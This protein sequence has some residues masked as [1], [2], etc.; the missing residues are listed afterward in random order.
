MTHDEDQDALDGIDLQMWRVPPPAPVDR[1]SLLVRALSPAAAP[2]RPRL[3]WIL[4]TIVLLNAALVTLVVI[5]LARSPE[6][7]TVAIV[8]PAGGG[9]VDEEVRVLLQRLEREQRELERKLAEIQ[10]LRA[11]VLELSE[12]VRQY[13]QQDG[14]RDRTVPK[15]PTRPAP[16]RIERQA[17]DPADSRCDEVYCVL[18]NYQGACCTKFRPAGMPVPTEPAPPSTLPETL[19]RAAISK[20]IAAVKARVANCGRRTEVS[21]VVKVRVRVG[22]D[23]R[24]TNVEITEA[25]DAMLGA[26]VAGEVRKA[27]F[28]QTQLGGSFGYPFVF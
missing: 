5:V 7:Q 26:C 13:E 23:G 10:E 8:Q 19:D 6:P 17:V 25:T 2:K 24:V 1:P 28:P 22:G 18:M 12:R 9:S 27:V 3:A 20:G 4:A 15:P 14:R 16:A 21:G 11:L